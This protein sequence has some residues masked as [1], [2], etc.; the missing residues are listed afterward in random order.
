MRRD[1]TREELHRLKKDLA[2]LQH[3]NLLLKSIRALHVGGFSTPIAVEKVAVEFMFAVGDLLEGRE[4]KEL[5]LKYIDK[6]DVIRE[7]EDGL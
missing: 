2:L 3:E 7:L 4:I 5:E 6:Q 1:I